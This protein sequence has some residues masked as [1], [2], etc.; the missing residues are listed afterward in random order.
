MNNFIKKYDGK[1]LLDA[2]ASVSRE[3][4]GFQNAMKRDLKAMAEEIGAELVDYH[5]G[6]Y[7]QSVFFHRNGH[8]V[9]FHYSR[10]GERS[11]P[12]L[13]GCAS[14]PSCYCRTAANAK[15]YRGGSNNHCAYTDVKRVVDRLLN[16]EHRRV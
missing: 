7:Y 16:E 11:T 3:Y 12:D 5:K 6:H 4:A 10:L 9:Y 13:T 1:Y 2:G 15:D 8:Y 14:F